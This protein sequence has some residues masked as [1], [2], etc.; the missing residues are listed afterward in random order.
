LPVVVTLYEYPGG[1]KE[2]FDFY[3]PG[4]S[5]SVSSPEIDETLVL[6]LS[7]EPGEDV[8][9]QY[10]K[11]TNA[12]DPCAISFSFS[13]RLVLGEWPIFNPTNTQGFYP[14]DY[15]PGQ[16]RNVEY[17][18]ISVSSLAFPFAITSSDNFT[19]R[20][21]ESW[22]V[23]SETIDPYKRREV[24]KS[25]AE[26]QSC[27]SP[28]QWP[29]ASETITGSFPAQYGQYVKGISPYPQLTNVVPW[30]YQNKA[31]YDPQY[32][33]DPYPAWDNQ[34]FTDPFYWRRILPDPVVT[35]TV[36]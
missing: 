7:Q 1:F 15:G 17:E 6:D 14:F 32:L 4:I 23:G 34:G 18:L 8:V 9:G 35:V 20:W 26:F 5:S 16:S 2:T 24:Q 29:T 25:P 30:Y 11:I 31:W 33:P 22:N 12:K 19:I 21:R 13:Y 3:A 27:T 36:S 10:G 28:N